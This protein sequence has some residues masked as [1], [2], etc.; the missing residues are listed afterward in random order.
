MEGSAPGH[1]LAKLWRM[2]GGIWMAA[3]GLRPRRTVE[4][5]VRGYVENDLL[6]YASAISFRVV[7]A[8]IPL[9]LFAL[10]VL[11]FL[12]LDEVWRRDIAHSDRSHLSLAGSGKRRNNVQAMNDAQRAQLAA[13]RDRY[14]ERGMDVHGFDED[15]S[16][17]LVYGRITG[18]EIAV[19]TVALDGHMDEDAQPD[20]ASPDDVVHA[21]EETR[22]R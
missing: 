18:A 5:L 2:A 13:L 22:R 14:R 6:T 20:S 3:R 16:L 8:L 1:P 7:F 10:G 19:H 9:G 21:D 11:G 12:Q 17:L 15:D 4:T